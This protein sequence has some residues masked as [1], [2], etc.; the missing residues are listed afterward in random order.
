MRH[1]FLA[2]ALAAACT[3]TSPSLGP[4]PSADPIVAAERAFAA[5]AAA[6]GWVAAFR[7]SVAADGIVLRP[8]IVSAP[9]VF[10]G[11]EDD[12]ERGLQWWPAFAGVARSGDF[13][14]TTGPAIWGGGTQVRG[15]YFTIWRRQSDGTWKW[16]FDGGVDVDD[17]NPIGRQA[18]VPTLPVAAR[19]AGSAEAAMAQVAEVERLIQSPADLAAH[20]APDV[21]VNRSGA[22]PAIGR[23]AALAVIEEPAQIAY[24]PLRAEASTAGDLVFTLGEARWTADGVERRGHY[25]RLWQLR[26]AGWRIVF[27]EILP[28]RG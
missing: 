9:A 4:T 24:A 20:L 19:G 7:A 1:A 12:A 11:L 28:R 16:I 8:D 6:R 15:H 3:T 27:D 10:A 23:D 17:A 18:V 14:F 13:G 25:A 5:D 26:A 22:A 21:R 2:A